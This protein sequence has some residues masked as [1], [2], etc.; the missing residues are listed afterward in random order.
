MSK[1]IEKYIEQFQTIDSIQAFDKTILELNGELE[2]EEYYKELHKEIRQKQKYMKNRFSDEANKEKMLAAKENVVEC[3]IDFLDREKKIDEDMVVIKYLKNFYLFMDALIRREPEKRATLRK[4][5]LQK[6][7]IQNE[8]DLQHLLYAV[9]KLNYPDIRKEVAED[10]GVGMVRSDLKIPSIN[11]VIEAKCTRNGMSLKKLTEEIEA[12]MVHYTD[13]YI[14]FFVYDKA[15]IIKEEQNYKKYFTRVFD[16]K[17]VEIV[18]Q[19]PI[20]L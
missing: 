5:D 10:S 20:E 18:I 7:Q 1:I 14:I 11:T 15:K 17:K 6:I 4:Y 12:D 9:L 16:G 3:L 19:Q 2:K 13:K 8:Y